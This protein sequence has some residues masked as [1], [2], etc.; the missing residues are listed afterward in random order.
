MATEQSNR[1][2]AR[3]TPDRSN[4]EL[5]GSLRELLSQ[6]DRGAILREATAMINRSLE[7]ESVW[8]TQLSPPDGSRRVIARAGS[9]SILR[10][11]M[12][13]AEFRQVLSM[14]SRYRHAVIFS[15]L[16]KPGR[17]N[18]PRAILG[19]SHG[20]VIVCRID[21]NRRPYGA[22]TVRA[23]P[24]APF[25]RAEAKLVDGVAALVSMLLGRLERKSSLRETLSHYRQLVER[26]DDVMFLATVRPQ[27]R[28]TYVSPGIELLTGYRPS[29]FYEKPGL[30]AKVVHP[31]D[32]PVVR[33]DLAEPERLTGTRWIRLRSRGGRPAWV[34]VSRSPIRD[35]RGRVTAVQGSVARVW[36]QVVEREALRSRA[37]AMA[38]ILQGRRLN[39]ALLTIVRHLRH[40]LEAEEVVVA[41]DRGRKGA[42]QILCR[43]GINRGGPKD[44]HKIRSDPIVRQALRSGRPVVLG[45]EL[46]TVIPWSSDRNGLL[47]GRG[48]AGD[49]AD[50]GQ[51]MAFV[52][53]FAREIATAVESMSQEQ[54]RIRKAIGADRSRIAR[55][56]HDGVVQTLFAVAL[57]FQLHADEVPDGLRTTIEQATAAVR[58]AIN[59]IQRY[60]YDL[61]PSL[62][63]PGGLAPSL[64]QLG[65]ELERSS[66][67]PVTV[68]FEPT[69][70]AALER[71]ATD[72]V[73]IVREA[74][75]NI[76]RHAGAGRVALTIRE[77]AHAT[78]LEVRDDGRGFSP[79]AARGLGLRNLRTR[80]RQLG[81]QLELHSE[82]GKGSVVRLVVP[83]PQRRPESAELLP[84]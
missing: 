51:A 26:G 70:V 2:P 41:A 8:I 69:A 9:M 25:G 66:G 13:S 36:D 80:A 22:L 14:I 81:G 12:G 76:R 43:D 57:R 19:R 27:L 23:R 33:A 82:P 50:R 4:Q 60:V 6:R 37:E 58:E 84:A 48:L 30:I 78:V 65:V 72:V 67:I 24:D 62:A 42:L 7:P 35:P 63:M 44:G 54:E 40:L 18:S 79:E 49:D 77:A 39:G 28:I 32:L 15:D 1:R 46:A 16:P 55:E 17:G 34:S 61:E 56:L 31:D 11:L 59:D 10:Q 53:R 3:T 75:S 64:E 20:R 68:K 21:G 83:A 29:D 38:A 71:F 73:Q 47:I 74:L 5:L 52:D 45:S